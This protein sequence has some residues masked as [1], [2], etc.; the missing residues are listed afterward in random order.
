MAGV[1]WTLKY[2]QEQ[3]GKRTEDS[4]VKWCYEQADLMNYTDIP[5]GMPRLIFNE[6]IQQDQA[7]IGALKSELDDARAAASIHADEHRKARHEIE[8]LRAALEKIGQALPPNALSM[9][10]RKALEEK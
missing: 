5:E 2:L 4:F 6:V 3:G 10:A 7:V 1:E 9:V 8:R